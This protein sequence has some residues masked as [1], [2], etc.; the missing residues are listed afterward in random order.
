MNTL[1][2]AVVV[3]WKDIGELV[4]S[5]VVKHPC[6]RTGAIITRHG[7]VRLALQVKPGEENQKEFCELM[8]PFRR[9]IFS[10]AQLECNEDGWIA[11]SESLTQQILNSVAGLNFPICSMKAL[12]DGRIFLTDEIEGW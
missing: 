1:S 3:D 12:H 6:I 10:E 9:R 11:L 8:E 2:Q 4:Q 5:F 7:E